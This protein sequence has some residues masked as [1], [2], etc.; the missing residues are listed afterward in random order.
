M[1]KLDNQREF[2]WDNYLVNEEQT[3][4]ELRVHQPVRKGVSIAFDKPW[5]GDGCDYQNIVFDP[6]LNKYRM[7]YLGWEM[8]NAEGTLHTITEIHVCLMESEDGIHWERPNLGLYEFD[9]NK[10]NNIVVHKSQF[11][12]EQYYDNANIDNF[13][14][15]IDPNPNPAVPGRYKAAMAFQ[16]N[17]PDGTFRR[18]L[19]ALVSDDGIHFDISS[20]I[21]EKGRF[22]TLNIIQWFPKTGLYHC[23]IRNFHMPADENGNIQEIGLHEEHKLSVA[24]RDIRVMTSPDFI[25]WTEPK[26]INFNDVEDYPLYT[27]CVSVYPRNT[28]MLVGF[29]T[30]Y[31]ERRQWTKNFDRLC[32]KEKREIRYKIV[33]RYG[34]TTTD[35]VFMCSRDGENWFRHDDALM[36]P[37]PEH[38]TN[39]VY[40]DCYPT[41]GLL[42]TPSDIAGAEPEMSIYAYENHWSGQ[43][44]FFVRYTLRWDGFVSRHAGIAPKKV[45][46]KEFTFQGEQLR[47]NFDTSARGYLYIRLRNTETGEEICSEEIFGN[48]ID[49]IV[50]FEGDVGAFAGKPVVMEIDLCDAD[51]YAIQFGKFE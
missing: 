27:N 45:V 49:R 19:Y 15:M 50:D 20:I 24:I 21:T 12:D 30:R 9:G 44:T 11:Y 43:A 28:N 29:P 3:T 2:F 31:V 51:I 37:G 4:A 26:L 10:E 38:P 39:W 22:D 1:I 34:L 14:V 8:L 18:G 16:Y 41:V 40:G 13:F 6:I 46:T 35:C 17:Q 7:Y 42:N 32:G 47:I 48:R 25:H 36:R 33:P 5:E 23:F